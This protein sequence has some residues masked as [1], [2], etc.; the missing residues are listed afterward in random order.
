ML[1]TGI[2][3]SKITIGIITEEFHFNYKSKKIPI[4][5]DSFLFFSNIDVYWNTREIPVFADFIF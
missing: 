5:R 2:N 4:A 3:L 1:P